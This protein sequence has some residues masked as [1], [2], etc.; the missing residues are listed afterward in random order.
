MPSKYNVASLFAGIGGICL[1]FKEAGADIVWANEIDKYACHLA[2]FSLNPKFWTS[3]DNGLENSFI[4]E[5]PVQPQSSE[6]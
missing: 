3:Y 5:I 6:E 4:A 2:D 1:G